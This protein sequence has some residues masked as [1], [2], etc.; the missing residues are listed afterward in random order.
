MASGIEWRRGDKE[1]ALRFDEASGGVIQH[2][3]GFTHTLA[4]DFAQ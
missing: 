4:S 1:Y 2:G 3:T